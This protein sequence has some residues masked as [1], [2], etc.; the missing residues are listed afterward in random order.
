MRSLKR[1]RPVLRPQL[2]TIASFVGEPGSGV[3]SITIPR[4]LRGWR[5][6]V[7]AAAAAGERVAI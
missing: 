2:A 5:T 3:L 7:W 4:Y 1:Q 6:A